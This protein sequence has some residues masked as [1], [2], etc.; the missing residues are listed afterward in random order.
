MPDENGAKILAIIPARG[1][2]KGIPRKNLR[3]LNGRPLIY[4]SIN[5]CLSSKYIDAVLVSTDDEEI[6]EISKLYGAD[7]IIRPP[8]LA[9][10]TTTLDPVVYHATHSFEEL[11]G[12]K[13]DY[14]VT[15]Q[16]TSPLLTSETLDAAIE[17]I[18]L[19]EYDTLIA[20]SEKRHLYWIK[21][22]NRFIPMYSERKNRQQ[23]SPIYQETGAF[24]IT[25]RGLFSLCP[26][27]NLLI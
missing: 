6:Y 14:V 15:I 12:K 5:T 7:A 16:P 4:Y 21:E 24:L 10:D 23:L 13:Y 27:T 2:S 26:H 25:K 19:K 22:E 3:I 1:G 20:G 18:S 11:K 17:E 8:H 9:E